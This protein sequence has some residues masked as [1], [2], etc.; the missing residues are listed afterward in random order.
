MAIARTPLINGIALACAAVHLGLILTGR[1]EWAAFMGGFIPVRLS[2]MADIAGAVPAWLTP[3]SSA[4]LHGSLIHLALNL[5]ML[6]FIGRQLEPAFGKRGLALLLLAG[7]YAGSLLHWAVEPASPIPVV[8][9]SGAISALVAAFAFIFNRDNVRRIG[10]FSPVVVRAAWLAA[11][12]IG[13]QL[14]IGFAFGGGVAI[15]A[16]IGG[17][18]AGL[19][20]TRPLLRW[21]FR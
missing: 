7:A 17:F 8:G 16:H 15:Y 12:W 10:P 13:V 21:R 19:V 11:A 1:L 20:L 2:G 5:M 6:V 18:L 9:A 14:A 4:F 3:L